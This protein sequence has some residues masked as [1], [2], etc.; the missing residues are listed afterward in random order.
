MGTLIW[1][2]WME[3]LNSQIYGARAEPQ[4]FLL[5]TDDVIIRKNINFTDLA[6]FLEAR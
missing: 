1:F 3:Y 6:A 4:N 5:D 2:K